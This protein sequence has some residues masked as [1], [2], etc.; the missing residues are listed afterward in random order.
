MIG[1]IITVIRSPWT[2]KGCPLG[3][4]GALFSCFCILM[5]TAESFFFW[6]DEVL[7][8]S[9]LN[10]FHS[11][12]LPEPFSSPSDGGTIPVDAVVG[13]LNMNM[14]MNCDAILGPFCDAVLAKDCGSH[15]NQKIHPKH[16]PR[17][18]YSPS[19]GLQL[20]PE[21]TYTHPTTVYSM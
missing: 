9:D 6:Y 19:H 21:S 10:G 17:Q 15:S 5:Y 20:N 12:P 14:N 2:S 8:Y 4:S 1:V 16:P 7:G 13:L 3:A 11:P 18:W